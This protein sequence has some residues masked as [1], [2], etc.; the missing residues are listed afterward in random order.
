MIGIDPI[1]P[2]V[3]YGR[4]ILST[5]VRTRTRWLNTDSPDLT[6]PRNAV[7]SLCHG[8]IGWYAMQCADHVRGADRFKTALGLY[9]KNDVLLRTSLRLAITRLSHSKPHPDSADIDE[10]I[11]LYFASSNAYPSVLLT[12]TPQVIPILSRTGRTDEIKVILESWYQLGNVIYLRDGD[13]RIDNQIGN[14]TSMLAYREYFP[15]RLATK[16][17]RW[18]SEGGS[19]KNEALSHFE[20][21]LCLAISSYTRSKLHL[22]VQSLRNIYL[23]RLRRHIPLYL[24]NWLRHHWFKIFPKISLSFSSPLRARRFRQQSNSHN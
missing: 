18:Q 13:P 19:R 3:E 11:D 7:L 2:Y 9:P 15:E 8:Y 16:I 21:M 12:E 4:D 6:P 1:F 14:M 5:A 22:Y 23:Q 20:E 10:L 24:H 17:S